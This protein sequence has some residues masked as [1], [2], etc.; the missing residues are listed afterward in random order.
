MEVFTTI[1]ALLSST[2]GILVKPLLALVVLGVL[3]VAVGAWKHGTLQG[4]EP[5][6]AT[7]DDKT[8]QVQSVSHT[9]CSTHT[10]THRHTSSNDQHH[11]HTNN[12]PCPNTQHCAELKTDIKLFL[13]QH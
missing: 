7:P 10:E 4:K 1:S 6:T 2:V 12:P 5:K 11:R 9:R 3:L 8:K 13:W